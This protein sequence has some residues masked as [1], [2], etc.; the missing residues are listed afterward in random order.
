MNVVLLH[1]AL[2]ADASPDEADVFTQ[3]G[4]VRGALT[5]LGHES[6]TLACGLDLR[7]AADELRRTKPALVFNLVESIGG[8]GRLIHLAP[9]M[10]DALGVPYTGCPM[11]AVYCTSNKLLAKRLLHGAGIATPE[12]AT[13]A[14]LRSG[15]A[16]A[17]GRYIVKSVWEHASRGLDEDS[18]IEA[19]GSASLAS[20]LGS[21]LGSLGGEGFCERYIDGREFNLSVLAGEVLPPAEIDFAA[22]GPEKLRVVGYRA[23]WDESSF[24]YHHTP[25]RFE[26]PPTDA[27]LLGELRRLALACWDLFS[28]RGY[29]RV[30][31]RVD[32][33]GKPWVLEVNTNPCLSPDAGFAAAVDRAGVRFTDAVRRIIRDVPMSPASTNAAPEPR[34]GGT[35]GAGGVIPPS[36]APRA[37]TPQGRHNADG[38]E[39]SISFRGEPR[40]SDAA[41]VRE[42]VSSTGFFHDFEVEVAVELVKERLDRGLASEYYFVFADDPAGGTIGY[43]CFGPVACTS[44]SFDL[45]WIAI[46]ESVRGRGLGLRIMEEAERRMKAGL[47]APNG[48]R[49][50]PARRVYIETSSKPQYEPTRGFYARC[51]YAEEARF[52]DFYAPGDDKVVYVRS[53][54]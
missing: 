21:R 46:H 40:I 6:T 53:L 20:A 27:G 15:R 23:K 16:P 31:F 43:A 17:A 13:L 42:I 50:A 54:G 9:A 1:D 10:L 5:Q 49:L 34:S 30:D 22:Y 47:P 2:G 19:R 38:A 52:K 48:E 26:Y 18:V 32:A 33:A 11:D 35:T 44:G 7:A 25:R 51:G 41:A 8:Q 37:G 14:D 24:E 28:L 45:Y 39:P 3:I 36:A 12:W 4:A 29:A